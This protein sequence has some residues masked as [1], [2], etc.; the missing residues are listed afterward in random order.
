MRI[1]LEGRE[2]EDFT[3]AVYK[4]AGGAISTH[5]NSRM[6]HRPLREVYLIEGSK[7]TVTLECVG[8]WSFVSLEP[9][10]MKKY[11]G[12]WEQPISIDI[13]GSWDLDHYIE[14]TWMYLGSLREFCR[15]I[16]KREQPGPGRGID[17]LKSVEAIN[18]AYLSA[19]RNAVI[20]LPLAE[21][22]EAEKIFEQFARISPE[23]PRPQ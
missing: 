3:Q 2:V 7:A 15:A 22:Y 1:L 5:Y 8:K 16:E 19:H 20:P 6:T 9:F 17:G 12:G 13:Q 14:S 4:H 21:P 11:A 18:A 23:I 10:V